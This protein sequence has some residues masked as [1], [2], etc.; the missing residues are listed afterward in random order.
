MNGHPDE[1]GEGSIEADFGVVDVDYGFVAADGGHRAF[2]FVVEGFEVGTLAGDCFEVVGQVCGL[3]EGDAGELGESFGEVGVFHEGDVADGEDIGEAVDPVVRIDSD[4]VGWGDEG[5]V[6][7]TGNV[8]FDSCCPDDEA[9]WH[10]GAVA[11]EYFFAIVGFDGVAGMDLD[12]HFFEVLARGGRS[13]G[14]HAGQGVGGAFDEEYVHAG[15][16][17]FGIVFG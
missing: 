12:A 6:D 1:P 8:S 10:G 17:Q 7:A 5:R 13:G 9:C 14:A 2:V 16:V 11:E 4:A 15:D 3:S